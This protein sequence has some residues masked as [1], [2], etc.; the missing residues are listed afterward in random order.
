M[1]AREEQGC[2]HPPRRFSARTPRCEAWTKFHRL[3]ESILAPSGIEL[4][5]KTLPLQRHYYR[6]SGLVTTAAGL[7]SVQAN[8][9]VEVCCKNVYPVDRV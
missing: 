9:V 2:H 4:L 8:I 5:P 6:C 3:F 7:N 1:A